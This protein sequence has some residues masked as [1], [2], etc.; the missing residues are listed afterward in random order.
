MEFTLTYTGQL[1]SQNADHKSVRANKHDIR[2]KLS[3]Q[4]ERLW[5][6]PPLS[7]EATILQPAVWEKGRPRI[8]PQRDGHFTHYRIEIGG[9]S[10][11]PLA[12]DESGL[13]VELGVKWLRQDGASVLERGGDI[14]NRLKTLFDAMQ[15]PQPNQ[16]DQANPFMQETVYCLVSDDSLITGL[17]VATAPLLRAPDGTNDV[18]LHIGVSV[19]RRGSSSF[20]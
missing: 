5:M 14:D 7:A 10:Y 17:S 3:G 19:K 16:V 6:Q 2:R 15:L 12:T 20:R 8:T 11:I 4:I 9:V 1:L 18:E 13:I